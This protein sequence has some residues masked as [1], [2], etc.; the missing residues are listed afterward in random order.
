[1]KV[2]QGIG[3]IYDVTFNRFT[4]DIG[5]SFIKQNWNLILKR[6]PPESLRGLASVGGTFDTTDR[7]QEVKQWYASHPVPYGSARVS[8]MLESMHQEVL[9]RQRYAGR[10]QQWLRCQ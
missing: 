10:I 3:M 5:W 1:V 2:K 7:E 4:R 9:F 6:F 8:R